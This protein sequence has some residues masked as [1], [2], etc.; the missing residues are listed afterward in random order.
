[1]F[2][3]GIQVRAQDPDRTLRPQQEAVTPAAPE[4][5]TAL[6]IGNG[7][8]RSAPLRNP[9]QDARAIAAVL[10]QCGFSVTLLED[11]P[12]V[13][14]V[15]ALREFG[16]AIQ[17]GGVGL[18]Y[19]A[20]HGMQVKGKNY[21]VPVD[22]DLASED[23]VAY[24]T[25]DADAV[26]AKM[27]S[28]RNRL[29]ILIL[30]ACRNNPFGRS[31]RS[32]SQGLAQ[33]DAPAGSYIAFATSP[34]HTA[35]DGTGSHGLYTQYLL[36]QM[37]QP[38]LRV[39]DVFK[40]VRAGV[41]QASKREQVPWES[42][43][44]TGD[45]FFVPVAG[46]EAGMAPMTVHPSTELATTGTISAPELLA[47][48]LE[49]RGGLAALQS[50]RTLSMSGKMPSKQGLGP[51]KEDRAANGLFR[52]EQA[53]P[54]G[55]A[56]MVSDGTRMT[57][58]VLSLD[59][60]RTLQETAFLSE[61]ET[62]FMRIAYSL[63]DDPMRL[64]AEGLG[65]ATSLPGP[66]VNGHRVHVLKIQLSSG[67]EYQYRIDP[68]TFLPMGFLM[69]TPMAGTV[70][71]STIHL[72]DY[73][74]I[75]GL[76][77]PFKLNVFDPEKQTWAPSLVIEHLQLN[78]AFPNEHFRL[79]AVSPP[80]QPGQEVRRDGRFLA[81]DNGTVLDTSTNL[82]W[83]ARDNGYDVDWAKAKS[84]CAAYRGGGFKDWRL[85]TQDELA[86][87]YDANKAHPA[88]CNRSA[89]IAVATELIDVT[90]FWE[91]AAESR[92]SALGNDVGAF[93][94]GTGSKGWLRQSEGLVRRI[95]PVR[96]A[97]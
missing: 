56:V 69:R 76:Q 62:R 50:I 81:Y 20:G 28:A 57:M 8:Y 30:D 43:S 21:L 89:T 39:E 84:Y 71:E 52:R 93:S 77:I 96:T 11:A 49:A 68:T 14:M 22:S 48:V 44:I 27:E 24:N 79:E 54:D 13:R 18:F 36:N 95:L 66:M 32:A 26:L 94:F 78:P 92:H 61:D 19:F 15:G 53:V 51:F 85:P 9:V 1:L 3:L 29:N 5:R 47:K 87:L 10:R 33:M 74:K 38:G 91:W 35:A 97:K 83:A 55:L 65:Q 4:A 42:S 72:L 64:C 16:Q 86:G 60:T 67:V 2:L 6:V 46:G 31:F 7:A 73:R 80:A 75:G 37:T 25:L 40:R 12:R 45:F 82:L 34:G 41:M 59:G 23:E 90:C 70:V 17:G 88:A 63:L 58:K